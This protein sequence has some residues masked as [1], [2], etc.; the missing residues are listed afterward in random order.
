MQGLHTVRVKE[1]GCCSNLDTRGGSQAEIS[2]GYYCALWVRWSK[3]TICEQEYSNSF[4]LFNVTPTLGF[5]KATWNFF[6]TSH[7]KRA[8]DGISGTV[9]ELL[10][11]WGNDVADRNTFFVHVPNSFKSVLLQYISEEDV[12]RLDTPHATPKRSKYARSSRMTGST[13]Q[14]SC[15]CHE[16]IVCR[17][18]SLSIYK[19]DQSNIA[20]CFDY[21]YNTKIF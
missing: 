14:L 3:Q 12:Q 20:P 21:L 19:V 1:T 7:S 4:L 18:F 13:R 16:M 17:C 10:M 2:T 15:F 9:K 11:P 5:E 8:S 6:P